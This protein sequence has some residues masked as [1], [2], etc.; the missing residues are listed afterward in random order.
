MC[1]FCIEEDECL[2]CHQKIDLICN[3]FEPSPYNSV[4]L[5][6]DSSGMFRFA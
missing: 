3:I 6:T 2:K 4:L 5:S 1:T